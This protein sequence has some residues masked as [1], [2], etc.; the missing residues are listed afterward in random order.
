MM[1][2]LYLFNLESYKHRFSAV[3][4]QNAKLE[5]FLNKLM[6]RIDR[7]C[8]SKTKVYTCHKTQQ[9]IRLTEDTSLKRLLK[10]LVVL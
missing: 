3:P 9:S 5:G 1:A 7:M 8:I 2:I 4:A 10:L 6:N